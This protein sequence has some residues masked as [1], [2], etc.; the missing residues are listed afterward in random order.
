MVETFKSVFQPNQDAADNFKA[1]DLS[2]VK[3]ATD[4]LEVLRHGVDFLEDPSK[5]NSDNCK[6]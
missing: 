5:I 3:S 6:M 2:W 4:P 1:V